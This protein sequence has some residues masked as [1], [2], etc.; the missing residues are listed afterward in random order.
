MKNFDPV[1][2]NG[3]YGNI[4]TDTKGNPFVEIKP[5]SSN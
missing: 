5:S 2:L 3:L 1:L 4:P